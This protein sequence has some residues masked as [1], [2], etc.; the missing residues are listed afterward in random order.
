MWVSLFAIAAMISSCLFVAAVAM[1]VEGCDKEG[2][3]ERDYD[4]VPHDR[5]FS[6]LQAKRSD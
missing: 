4:Q 1:D 6:S 3:P 2:A 5:A